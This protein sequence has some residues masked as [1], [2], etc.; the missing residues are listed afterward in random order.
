MKTKRKVSYTQ[1]EKSRTVPF[2]RLSGAWLSDLGYSVGSNFAISIKSD[3]II[4]QPI[5]EQLCKQKQSTL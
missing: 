5:K 3:Q 4:L 1:N 2:I